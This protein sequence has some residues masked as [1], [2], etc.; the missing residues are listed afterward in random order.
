M[1]IQQQRRSD[2]IY[3]GGF[4]LESGSEEM[5]IAVSR[6]EIKNF[7]YIKLKQ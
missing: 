2:Y 7:L 6:P 1:I 4:L 3:K 5:I